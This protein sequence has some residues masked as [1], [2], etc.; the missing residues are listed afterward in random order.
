MALVGAARRL[1]VPAKTRQDRDGDRVLLRDEDAI[2]LLLIRMGAAGSITAW[3]DRWTRRAVPAAGIQV[4]NFDHANARRATLAAAATTA[5][6]RRALQILGEDIPDHL[7]TAARLRLQYPQDSLEQLGQRA[8]PPLT[9]DAIAGRVRRL[10]ITA[11][12]LA[13]TLGIP[14]T[15]AALIGD[16][17]RPEHHT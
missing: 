10:L 13:H 8:D 5:R 4:A 17:H 7:L 3:R 2:T 1:G 11:D 16:A 15:E 12:T 6:V 9:K 14:D